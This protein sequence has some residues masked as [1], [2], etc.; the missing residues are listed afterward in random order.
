MFFVFFDILLIVWFFAVNLFPLQS[1][2]TFAFQEWVCR[3]LWKPSF[4]WPAAGSGRC[5]C[6]SRWC[7]CW[8]SARRSSGLNQRTG[9]PW[10]AAGRRHR[11]RSRLRRRTTL[12]LSWPPRR[13]SEGRPARTTVRR[14]LWSPA[15]WE[16][17]WRTDETE[18]SQPVSERRL[19]PLF[20]GDGENWGAFL[21][22][23]STERPAQLPLAEHCSPS[24]CFFSDQEIPAGE[25]Q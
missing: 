19:Q 16:L 3:R 15:C 8:S 6:G 4:T 13:L 17:A 22:C 21:P 10:A 25:M 14:R 23:S 11:E 5:R 2:W 9:A 20:A 18:A 24:D 7:P 1:W 12:T